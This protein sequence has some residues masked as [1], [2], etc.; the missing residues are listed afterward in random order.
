MCATVPS[1]PVVLTVP[2]TDLS[3]AIVIE[4][5]PDADVVTGGVS[6]APV[7]CNF[8]SAPAAVPRP[9]NN[10]AAATTAQMRRVLKI[11]V[12]V[13]SWSWFLRSVLRTHGR[14]DHRSGCERE[15]AVVK[16]T[17]I[18]PPYTAM[19][20]GWDLCNGPMLSPRNRATAETRVD[21][22]AGRSGQACVELT[23]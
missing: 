2:V 11:L 15:S 22:R 23:I 19:V 17:E 8:T 7:R 4:P 9:T 16:N 10:A 21:P 5:V 3:A 12:I 1:M 14:R 13:H 18:W 20:K 6:S